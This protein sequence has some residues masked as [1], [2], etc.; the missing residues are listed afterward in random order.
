MASLE[1][2]SRDV[3][4]GGIRGGIRA[5]ITD[6][7]IAQGVQQGAANAAGAAGAANAL[8]EGLEIGQS[9][10]ETVE[11]IATVAG[12]AIGAFFG[13]PYGAAAGSFAGDVLGDPLGNL[14]AGEKLD[15]GEGLLLTSASGAWGGVAALG[16]Q[17]WGRSEASKEGIRR[18]KVVGAYSELGL[19]DETGVMELPDGSVYNV[20]EDGPKA[21]WA[22]P[23]KR[24]DK[25][26]EDRKLESYEIDY[27]NDLDY[28]A[29][30]AGIT[31]SRLVGGGVEKHVD[32]VGNSMGNA[33][34]G[35]IGRGGDFSQENFNNV[36]NN[37]RSQYAK[38]GIQS[39]DEML[40]LANKMYSEGRIEDTDYAVMQQ[41][42][43]MVFDDDYNTAQQLMNGRWDGVATANES[44]PRPS[45]MD[46]RSRPGMVYP[47]GLFMTPEEIALSNQPLIDRYREST[48]GL[49]NAG[50]L[51]GAATAASILGGGASALALINKLTGGA[52]MEGAGDIG[53][54]IL[55]GLG[56]L[57][58][59]ADLPI[60]DVPAADAL[61]D[62]LFGAGS[63][64]ETPVDSIFGF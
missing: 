52:L 54:D 28:T 64:L 9:T 5:A 36:M 48:Q 61:A 6:S 59:G 34:L 11:G 62:E 44:A 51:G 1:D 38:A 40:A 47:S 15:F 12:T 45:T 20:R 7:G 33:M 56:I 16:S 46:P 42:A 29:G 23:S 22:N 60:P 57:D 30:M 2:A 19:W 27:T 55:E 43:S 21:D 53:R 24:T 18:D 3:G 63:I 49:R 13:G 26:G 35:N 39:K 41:T 4:R 10:E 32:Q 31:L 17:I 50:S 37:A 14:A 8:S 58:G 25:L